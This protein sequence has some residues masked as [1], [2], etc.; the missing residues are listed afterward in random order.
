MI[1]PVT[2]RRL[3]LFTALLAGLAVVLG[4]VGVAPTAVAQPGFRPRR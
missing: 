4:L 3:T 2:V 1:V